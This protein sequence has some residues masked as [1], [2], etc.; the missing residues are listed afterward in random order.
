MQ[1][2]EIARDAEQ[3]S[4]TSIVVEI[5][6]GAMH[7]VLRAATEVLRSATSIVVA[8]IRDGAR[9][10]YEPSRLVA[11]LDK[12]SEGHEVPRSRC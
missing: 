3:T 5:A 2:I 10:P 12:E 1:G 11:V 9:R 7:E 6:R 8:S 4:A